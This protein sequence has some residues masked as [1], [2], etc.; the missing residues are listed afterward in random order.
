MTGITPAG[1]AARPALRGGFKPGFELAPEFFLE[2]AGIVPVEQT[3][4]T[5][6]ALLGRVG[7]TWEFLDAGGVA[8]GLETAGEFGV[9]R[10]VGS[11]DLREP[12]TEEQPWVAA[13]L[14]LSLRLPADSMFFV[15]VEV[16]PFVTFTRHE[17]VITTPANE[18]ESVYATPA[19]GGRLSGF[20]GFFL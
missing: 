8:I 10:A 2:I 18:L 13:D 4:A 16:G 6:S 14:G 9:V 1:V 7:I 11:D 3:E 12:L 20:V 5:Y 19:F 17:Y 15:R